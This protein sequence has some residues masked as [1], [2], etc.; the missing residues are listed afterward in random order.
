MKN[1][2]LFLLLL[3]VFVIPRVYSQLAVSIESSFNPIC[4]G[5]STTLTADT[6][7]GKGTI[8]YQWNTIPVGAEIGTSNSITV[9]PSSTTTYTVTV[10]DASSLTITSSKIITVNLNPTASFSFTPDNSC[11]Y[12]PISF[13]NSSTGTGLTCVWSFGDAGSGSGN[14]STLTNPSHTFSAST[15]NATQNFSVTLTVTNSSGCSVNITKS[16]TVKQIPD[17]SIDDYYSSV[18]FTN[19]GGTSFDLAIDNTSSTANSEYTI[20]WGDGTSQYS[21]AILPVTGTHHIY[22]AQGYF[23]LKLTVKG[24]NGCISSKTYSVFNG[25]NPAIGLVNPGSTVNLCVPVTLTFP[26][27]STGG[28]PPGTTYTLT[29]NTGSADVVF[30]H[31]PPTEYKHT[32]TASSCGA[33]GATIN[34]SF[35]IRIK[36]YNPCGLS[37][38]TI[39]PITTSIKPVANFTIS[40]A[41]AIACTSAPVTFTNTSASGIAVNNFGKCDLTTKRNWKISPSVGWSVTSGSLGDPNPTEKQITWGS[42]SLGVSFSTPG[43]YDISMVVGNACGK[44]SITKTVCVEAPITP[45]FTLSSSIGC[46]PLNVSITNTSGPT[47]GTA[48]SLPTYAWSVYYVAGYCGNSSL[49]EYTSG[50][51]SSSINPSFIFK[52]SGTYTISL[53]ATN[54]CGT[55]N[56]SQTV[57]VTAPPEAIISH[58]PDNCGPF[59]V[60]PVAI[61][62]NCGNGP[63][64][65]SWTFEGGSPAVSSLLDPGPVFFPAVGSHKISLT[66]TN[67]CGETSNNTSFNIVPLPSSNAGLVQTICQGG[68]VILAGIVGGSALGGTW[69]SSGGG[70]FN[71]NAN[72]L[73]ATWTPPV[74][75]AGKATLTLTTTGIGP[76]A[77]V[78]S[79]IDIT[80]IPTPTAEAGSAPVICQEGPVTLTGTIGGSA[81]GGTWTT[82]AGGTFSP[83]ENTLITTWIPPSGYSGIAQLTLATT[84]MNSC[85][86][87]TSSVNVKVSPAPTV[88]AGLDQT[89]CPGGTVKLHGTVGGSATG[90]TWTSSDGGTFTPDVNAI[91]AT[92]APPAGFAGTA[93]LTLTTTGMSPCGAVT[94]SINITVST[95][96]TVNAGTAQSMCQAGTVTLAGTVGGSATG[97]TWSASQAG[98]FT[99]DANTLNATWEAPAGYTGIVDF[100]LSTTGMNTCPVVTSTVKVTVIQ[101]PVVNAGTDQSICQ[102]GTVTLSGN[103]GGSATGA[104]WTTPAGG[105]FYPNANILNATWTPPP[106]YA[107]KAMLTLTT[108]G[109]GPCSAAASSVDITVSPT[110]TVNA[111]PAQTICQGGSAALTGTVGGSAISGKWTS[112]NGGSFSPDAST[113]NATWSPTAGYS[114][115]AQLTLTTTSAGSCTNVSTSVNITVTPTPTIA[116]PQDQTVCNGALTKLINFTGTGTV[117]TWT[118]DNQ[119]IGLGAGSSGDISSFTATNSGNTPLTAAITVTPLFTSGGVTCTGISKSFKITVNPSPSVNQPGSELL[120]KGSATKPVSFSGDGTSYTWT[121]NASAIGLAASGMGDIS[122][123]IAANSETTQLVAT[124]T[125]TPDYT[126][127]GLTCQGP[128]KVFTLKVN[129]APSVQ[130]SVPDQT[131]C[132]DKATTLV[133]LSSFTGGATIS[134]SCVE[135]TGIS[136]AISSGTKV[137]PAQKLTNSTHSPIT[138]SYIAVAST[139][140]D[141]VCPGPTYIY[142][143]VVNPTPDLTQP[144]DIVVC[145][146]EQTNL[147]SFIGTG[148]SYTWTNNNTSTGMGA[149]GTGSVTPFKA[150]NTGVNAVI[151]TIIVTPQYTNTGVSCPGEPKTFTITVNPS[152]SVQFSIADQ[153]I[154]SGNATTLVNIS[155]ATQGATISWNCI[156]PAGITGAILSGT[157]AVPVQTLTNSTSSPITVSYIAVASTTAGVVCP[158]LLYTYNIVVNPIPAVT[159]PDDLSVCNGSPTNAINFTGIG[160]LYDWTNNDPSIGLSAGGT[161]NISS[162]TA[163]NIGNKPVAALISVT[164]K[165]TNSGV[166][167]QGTPI[168]FSITV[169]PSLTVTQPASQ[170]ICN[171][172]ATALINFTGTGMFYTWTNNAVSIGLPASGTGDISSFIAANSGTEPVIATITVTPQYLNSGLTCPGIPR[173]FSITVNPTPTVTQ[174]ADLILCNGSQTN[175]V[176]FTGTGTFYTWTNDARSIGLGTGST[177]DISTFAATNAGNTPIVATITVTP[178]YTNQGVTCTGIPKIFKITVN[179]TPTVAQSVSQILCNGS[180]TKL[181]S[182][183]GVRTSYIW[184]NDAPS[185]GLGANGTGDIQPFI[186]TNSGTSP[187]VATIKVTPQYTTGAV[188]CPG[189]QESFTVT[190]NPSPAVQFSIPG[191][192]ICSDYATTLVNLTSMTGGATILW[193]CSPPSGISG[194]SLSG[195]TSIPVQMLTNSTSK[196]ITVSYIAVASTSGDLLCDGPSCTYAIIVNP[197]PKI[198]PPANLVICNGSQTDLIGFSGTGS[199]YTW[200]NNTGSIGLATSG[201][202]NISPFSI[203]NA[204]STPI[205]ATLTVTPQFTNAGITCPGEPTTFSLTV[206]PTPTVNQPESEVVCNESVT[207]LISFS[208]TGTSYSWTNN[209]TQIGL[210]ASGIGDISSFTATNKGSMPLGATI[211]ITPQYTNAGMTCPGL[212]KIITIV[213]NPTPG[214]AQVADQVVCNGSQSLPINYTGTGTSYTW[215]NDNQSIGLGAGGTGDIPAFTTTNADIIPV[216]ANLTVTPLFTN[217]GL[218]CPGPLMTFTFTVNP[219]PMVIQPESLITCT[220]SLT[221]LIGFSGTGTS[222]D[223]T[224]NDASI[225]LGASGTGDIP[226]FMA[227]NSGTQPVVALITVTPK[228]ANA[229]LICDGPSRS[230]N[231]TISPK[232]T[233]NFGMSQN[234]GCSPITIHFID[235]IE[236]FADNL[237]WDFGDGSPVQ[238]STN[239]NHSMSH[240]FTYFGV[241]DTTYIITLTGNNKCGTDQI[242]HSVTVSPNTVNAFFN[243]DTLSGCAPLTL[244][245]TNYS[246]GGTTYSWDFGDGNVSTLLNPAH[247]YTLPGKYVVRLAVTNGCSYDTIYSNT[248]NVYPSIVTTFTFNNKICAADTM[249]FLN[250]SAGITNCT[251]DFGDGSPFSMLTDPWHVYPVSG[252]YQVTLSVISAQYHCPSTITIPVIVNFTPHPSFTLNQSIGCSPLLVQFNNNTD[253]LSFNSYTWEF[254]NGS[255]SVLTTPIGQA[256]SNRSYCADTTFTVRLIA[257]NH[258]CADTSYKSITVHPI[259]KCDF[260]SDDSLFC[261]FNAPANIQFRQQSICAQG[262]Q[263]YIGD[264]LVST[265]KN[266]GIIF[267]KPATYDVSLVVANQFG[268]EATKTKKYIV[269]PDWKS[270]ISID[271]PT[272]CEPLGVTFQSSADNLTY[273]WDFGDNTTASNAQNYHVY[274]AD[275]IY[276]ILVNVVGEGGC[277]DNL[278]LNDKITVNQPASAGFSYQNIKIPPPNDGTVSFSNN[279]KDAT[280]FSWNFG[281]GNMYY[282]RDTIHRYLL[283]NNFEVTL[284]ANNQYNCPDTAYTNIDLAFFRGLFI[285]NAFSPSN[286]NIK[287]QNFFPIGIGLETYHCL[288]YDTWGNKLWES[289]ALDDQGRPTEYWDGRVSGNLLP[290]DAY[291]WKA[292]GTFKDGSIWPGMDNGDGIP[293]NYG[294]VTI[295]K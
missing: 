141:M 25:S 154:C 252:T 247:I 11:P 276:S 80:V 190:V 5:Q 211:T 254:N 42:S 58:I 82:Q 44:D 267:P 173:I 88:N 84:G 115:T 138:V 270:R 188:T 89:A 295:I 120:C 160:T 213:V 48:C 60:T 108:T 236:G 290:M 100:T 26:I 288:V 85:T 244:R 282:G 291:V 27:T 28:N 207:T 231:I 193:N 20:D 30:S 275:G 181:V 144:D 79:T 184:S 196:P 175:M 200:T 253:S 10:T 241:T 269:Y 279:S 237:V 61:A 219:T 142:N 117:Y 51:T 15:G 271:P 114:G 19:C 64:T 54:S 180:T 14:T 202:G 127:G 259:P 176:K 45:S 225:G 198:D 201:T 101:L 22:D 139:S 91:D 137:I 143:I 187:I 40:P 69:S 121:N 147:I 105:S 152:P 55:Y 112:S 221:T 174:P 265:N 157:T 77:A 87:V 166:I 32:F 13:T 240:T 119:A 106:A 102:G 268:C 116:Q 242:K 148:T 287:I 65:Y 128:K 96:S 43:T 134:W 29:T 159:K 132:S 9:T 194:A 12:T 37:V 72:T 81:T 185:I 183:E 33:T 284:I 92:W 31:P 224:N 191:Q 36:A 135:P 35:F 46:K 18:P 169:N 124:I 281:D 47:S 23:T 228:Y 285:P 118:N 172:S 186:T 16:I 286:S 233:V 8:T 292:T 216:T 41:T 229:G 220:E 70:T 177:G 215:T 179:P 218:T 162:F 226:P 73:N 4:L 262:F 263:W 145:N 126:N 150:V 68:T 110:S 164:P 93:I 264:T 245:F 83:D 206:N 203:V 71:P 209:A 189:S 258:N 214:A 103:A 155:S 163:L 49:W 34:N 109:M 277:R 251:W 113:L 125:V 76:C 272:G 248:I 249:F 104:A 156:Q 280:L 293:R 210:A 235:H 204:G 294:T 192:T 197:T 227:L 250:T 238:P 283:N 38:A 217:G 111:G 75:Y 232:P 95:I 56:T 67:E 230:F 63:T 94:S 17:A 66:V 273:V 99:P 21:S 62:P 255:S 261:N 195:T 208:G 86:V 151:A 136:G 52:N 212:S 260:I 182:F 167:C 53:A 161:G 2:K 278:M 257:K 246:R 149:G 50:T 256:F 129:P 1:N 123:F 199:S 165:Y 158:G 170:L 74:A 239:F 222:Y 205:V 146:G 223:W 266:P 3:F 243:T 140:I 24:L 6:S 90:G 107:G 133:D 39:E 97:G 122:S 289:T 274:Q 178:L 59:T 98:F 171:G 234:Y 7:G 57:I 131:I 78:S 168:T 130:F 153:T